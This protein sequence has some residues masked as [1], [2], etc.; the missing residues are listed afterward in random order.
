M[1]T[2][3]VV[4]SK[5][6]ILLLFTLICSPVV[7]RKIECVDTESP[8]DRQATTCGAALAKYAHKISVDTKHVREVDTVLIGTY[9]GV[10]PHYL[11]VICAPFS[12]R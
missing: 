5:L 11:I 10:P 6:L 8:C 2:G 1:G 12:G 3:V 9:D 4:F 7:I